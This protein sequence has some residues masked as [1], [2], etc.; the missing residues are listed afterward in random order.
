MVDFENRGTCSSPCPCDTQTTYTC[1]DPRVQEIGLCI[2]PL[3]VVAK[4]SIFV[5]CFYFSFILPALD[6]L[7]NTV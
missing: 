1:H 2:F 3:I 6:V 4:M 5:P 7:F